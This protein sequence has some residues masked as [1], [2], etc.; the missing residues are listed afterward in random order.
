MTSG[1][2]VVSKLE[3]SKFYF[4]SKKRF[5]IRKVDDEYKINENFIKELVEDMKSPKEDYEIR[6]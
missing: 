2:K 3:Y 5:Q 6:K 4:S 1:I